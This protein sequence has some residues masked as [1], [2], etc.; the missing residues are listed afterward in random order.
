MKRLGFLVESNHD[1]FLCI[2]FD[3]TIFDM[4]TA[5]PGYFRPF[6]GAR[7]ALQKFQEM[8][9]KVVVWSARASRFWPDLSRKTR[10]DE[11]KALLALYDIPFDEIDVGDIGK[12]PCFLYI[13]DKAVRFSGSWADVIQAVSRETSRTA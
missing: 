4:D 5:S 6:K 1:E 3:G 12:R 7:E 9:F 10:V 13:D 2:D 8:G 11:M